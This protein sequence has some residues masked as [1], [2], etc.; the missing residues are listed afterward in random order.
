MTDTTRPTDDYKAKLLALRSRAE[1]EM[2]DKKRE[3]EYQQGIIN[4][5]DFA[6]NLL[7]GNG[8]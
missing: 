7:K 8:V 2:R 6:L 4:G 1:K 5:L 3:T